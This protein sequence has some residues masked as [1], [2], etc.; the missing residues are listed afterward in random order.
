MRNSFLRGTARLGA[1]AQR[2]AATLFVTLMILIILTIIILSSSSV[3]LF[4]QKTATNEYRARLAEQAA[5][6]AL[7][8]GGEYLKVNVSKISTNASGGWLNAGSLKWKSCAGITA[9]GHPCTSETNTT[10]RAQLYYYTSDGAA[11]TTAS[12]ADLAAMDLFNGAN[13]ANA[14]ALAAGLS[15]IGGA[16]SFPATA[17]VYALLCRIDT[18]PGLAQD[19][20]C[21]LSPAQG[22]RLAVTLI[23]QSSLTGESSSATVR[24][25]WGTLTSDSF[26]ANTPL[27]AAGLVNIVGTFTVVDSPNAGGYG[28][29]ASIW[30]AQDAGGNGSWQTCQMEDYL[31]NFPLSQLYTDPGC[32]AITPSTCHCDTD[33]ISTGGNPDGIDI[34][35]KDSG[36]G[37][38]PDITFFPGSSNFSTQAQRDSTRM[39]YRLCT[40]TGTPHADCVTSGQCPSGHP[41]CLTDDNLF[42][43]IFGVDV[44][45]G[46]T[47]VVQTNCSVPAAFQNATNST[48]CEVAALADLN[49]QAIPNCNATYLNANSAGLFYV[50]GTCD[51]GANSS[52]AII[53]DPSHPVIIVTDNNIDFGKTDNFFGMMF[54]RSAPAQNA[55]LGLNHA[56]ISGNANGKFFG[57]IVVEGGAS[58]LNGTMDLIYMDTSAGNPNDPLPETTRFARLPNSWLDNFTGF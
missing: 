34:L 22:R 55:A 3:A 51:L 4:E 26:S 27:V 10:R 49:F 48:D 31:G 19:D 9:A 18:T 29:G 33:Q 52:S 41:G 38:N 16:S 14:K 6:Y 57:S 23:S 39:D 2:G 21:R 36:N 47:T 54:V 53:G 37:V 45:N 8:L 28:I 11:H 58:H 56:T 42:E 24:E 32:G 44:T 43:W 7:N 12:S 35:D 13:Q 40:G 50:T 30:S 17:N 25:T 15:T 5:E 20:R 46:D 1:R